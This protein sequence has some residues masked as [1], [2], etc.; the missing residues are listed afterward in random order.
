[1]NGTGAPA[2]SP[3]L[4]GKFREIL[5]TLPTPDGKRSTFVLDDPNLAL[6]LYAPRGSDPQTPHTRDEVYIV[7]E[8]T[9]EFVR[10]EERITFAP[11]DVF[12]AAAGL[13]HRFENFSDDFATWVLFYGTPILETERLRLRMF[14]AD[15][16]EA[17]ARIHADAEA[18]RY[19]G[20]GKTLSRIDAFRHMAMLAGH[21]QLRGY[22]IWAVVEKETNEFI[23][24]V[25]FHFPEGWPD[26]ELGWTI[27]RDRWGRGYATEA[28]S[29]ALRYAFEELGRKHVISLIH[30]DN[31]R[32]IA[33]AKKL[34]ETFEGETQVMGMRLLV[35]GVG[36]GG[37]F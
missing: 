8:G 18:M 19:L 1:M 6:K 37:T 15:D 21:W 12:F 5:A 13:K 27:A 14:I 30:P 28:A 11:R 24:R 9:G 26:F 29:R 3:A 36:G 4:L 35:Y 31:A 17:Y 23:G 16:F 34:G 25:G 33:V 7:A 2:P 22:G 32:S 20:E 10:E